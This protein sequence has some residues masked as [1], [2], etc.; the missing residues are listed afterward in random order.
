[1]QGMGFIAGLLLLYMQLT[2]LFVWCCADWASARYGV[3]C[4]PVAAVND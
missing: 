2:A 4:W 1:M 3:H